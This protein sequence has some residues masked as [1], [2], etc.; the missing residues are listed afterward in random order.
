MTEVNRFYR[1]RKNTEVL[2]D[3]AK[4][5]KGIAESIEQ[6]TEEVKIEQKFRDIEKLAKEVTARIHFED[7]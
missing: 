4:K 5:I 7:Y 3:Y 6:E 1:P 2:K